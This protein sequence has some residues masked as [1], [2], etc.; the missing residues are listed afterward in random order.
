[1]YELTGFDESDSTYDNF[2]I[3]LP[4]ARGNDHNHISHDDV[5]GEIDYTVV[6]PEDLTPLHQ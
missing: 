2:V 1:M 5:K 6:T 3:T 4:D